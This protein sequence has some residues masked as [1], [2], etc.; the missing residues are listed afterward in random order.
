M[1][2]IIYSIV[3]FVFCFF[4]FHFVNDILTKAGIDVLSW[5]IIDNELLLS[6]EFSKISHITHT[7]S[8]PHIYY[9]L[10][11]ISR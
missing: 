8:L 7:K 6:F 4:V 5:C 2:S 1:N 11:H 9:G 10:V 3:F